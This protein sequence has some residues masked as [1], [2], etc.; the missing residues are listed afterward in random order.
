MS[1]ASTPETNSAKPKSPPSPSSGAPPVPAAAAVE[2]GQVAVEP[3]DEPVDAHAEEDR[4]G[5]GRVHAGHPARTG[6]TIQRPPASAASRTT[7][8]PGRS[9]ASSWVT[10]TT[11][12]PASAAAQVADERRGGRRVQVRGRL[13]EQDDV[14][15][16]E[17]RAGGGQPAPL[18]AGQRRCRPRRPGCPARRAASRAGR[19]ARSRSAPRASAPRRPRRRARRGARPGPGWPGS[20]RR[21]RAPP[22]AATPSAPAGRRRRRP[23]AGAR[24]RA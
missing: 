24:P 10:Q 3:G 20:S 13:V 19:R 16:G 6:T 17:Q 22:A 5:E 4:S 2:E 1:S 23:G 18:A 7:V 8:S 12:R 21:R 11:T 9:T 15:V 14:A